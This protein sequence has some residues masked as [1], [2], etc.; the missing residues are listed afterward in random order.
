LT[1]GKKFYE[2]YLRREKSET[3]E[4]G[5]FAKTKSVEVGGQTTTQETQVNYEL[6]GL[7]S[8]CLVSREEVPE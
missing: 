3:L 2:I 5:H 8:F 4:T 7:G 1:T 6:S